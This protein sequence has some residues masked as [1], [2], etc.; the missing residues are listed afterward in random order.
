MVTIGNKAV[1]RGKD[2]V[3]IAILGDNICIRDA[4]RHDC[5]VKIGEAFVIIDYK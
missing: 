4:S 1:Y 3:V 2:Y 5:W